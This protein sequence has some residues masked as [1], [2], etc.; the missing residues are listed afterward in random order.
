[1]HVV[2]CTDSRGVGGAEISLANLVA[3]VDP[4]VRVDV[5]GV[6][7]TVVGRVVAGRSGT[8]S[9]VAPAARHP[10]L[11]ARLR[12][13]APACPA[14][15]SLVGRR[16]PEPAGPSSPGTAGSPGADRDPLIALPR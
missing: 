13:P 12:P 7:A 5:L 6:D 14:P 1:M 3:D 8:R 9:I 10:A 4:E 2:A 15:L 11:L 16:C